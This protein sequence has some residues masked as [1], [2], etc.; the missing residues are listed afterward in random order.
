[1]WILATAS[2]LAHS[3][4]FEKAHKGQQ[5]GAGEPGAHQPPF[6]LIIEL[7]HY[8]RNRHASR[9]ARR[10]PDK[11]LASPRRGGGGLPLPA[12]AAAAP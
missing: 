6:I 10:R 7:Y 12:A 11:T 4:S 5:E 3:S 2:L 8:T 9:A 1:M